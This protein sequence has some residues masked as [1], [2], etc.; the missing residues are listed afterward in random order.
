MPN[1]RPIIAIGIIAFLKVFLCTSV[2]VRLPF[3][4]KYVNANMSLI[5][6]PNTNMPMLMSRNKLPKLYKS[7]ALSFY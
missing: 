6:A 3:F 7:I 4:L 5:I 1:K 2:N